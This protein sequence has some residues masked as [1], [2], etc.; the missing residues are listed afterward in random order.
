M[1][2]YLDR[3][4]DVESPDFGSV[5]DEVSLWGARFGILLLDEVRIARGVRVL[6]LGSGTGFPLFELAH[7]LGATSELV[8][9]DLWRGALARAAYKRRA[10]EAKQ[11]ALVQADGA[12]LPFRTAAFDLIVS[13]LGVNNFADPAGAFGECARV[14]RPDG[15]LVLTTNPRGHF[16]EL[17]AAFREVF[18]ELH[19]GE[20][21]H[22]RL[23]ADENH[24]PDAERL[25]EMLAGANLTV[26]RTVERATVLRYLDGSAF[27]RHWLIRLG[28]LPD[29]R[30]IV[31]SEG[32]A[33]E[34]RVFERLEERLNAIAAERGELRM[35]LPLLYLEA[36][37][38]P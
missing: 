27:L 33:A 10:Y 8:G 1:T 38:R 22:A 12:G 15:Q 9:V 18:A 2:D 25:R 17:Y 32:S 19:L 14:L 6:D 3:A 37:H 21:A 26:T 35:T 23:L 20:E 24:R 34:R 5:W 4:V 29:W 36:R 11:V 30:K 16:R 13:N 28:F 31:G 7:G